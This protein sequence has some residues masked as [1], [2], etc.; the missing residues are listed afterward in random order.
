MWEFS[1]RYH[2]LLRIVVIYPEEIPVEHGLEEMVGFKSIL[3]LL[4]ICNIKTEAQWTTCVG[5]PLLGLK[6]EELKFKYR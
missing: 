5:I 3:G 6:R 2:G 1:E 4:F